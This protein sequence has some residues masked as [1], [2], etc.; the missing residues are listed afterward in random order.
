MGSIF[1]DGWM[2]FKLF[3]LKPPIRSCRETLPP[4]AFFLFTRSSMRIHIFVFF[5]GGKYFSV[6]SREQDIIKLFLEYWTFAGNGLK[7]KF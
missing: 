3:F 7:L 5:Y 6:I 2:G 1:G 4:R